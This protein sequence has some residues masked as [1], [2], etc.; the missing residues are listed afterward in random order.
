MILFMGSP[1][2]YSRR[3]RKEKGSS[4]IRCR[5]RTCPISFLKG[6]SMPEKGMVLGYT[7]RWVE[8]GTVRYISRFIRRPLVKTSACS[9]S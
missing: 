8:T 5:T 3:P 7:Y 4:Y 2:R 1:G 9:I 6:I